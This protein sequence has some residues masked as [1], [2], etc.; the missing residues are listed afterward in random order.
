MSSSYDETM[1]EIKQE[2]DLSELTT[3]IEQTETREIEQKDRKETHL[4]PPSK[5]ASTIPRFLANFV[6]SFHE[7]ILWTN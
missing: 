7:S 1:I 4:P 2:Y 3:P 6:P 5:Q